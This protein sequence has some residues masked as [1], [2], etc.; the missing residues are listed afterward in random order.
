MKKIKCHN[1]GMHTIS[2]RDF[3]QVSWA[4]VALPFVS[5]P[6]KAGVSETVIEDKNAAEKIIQTCSTFDCGGKC[7]MRAHIS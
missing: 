7:D 5:S 3:L 6:L 1:E 2:R 4:L